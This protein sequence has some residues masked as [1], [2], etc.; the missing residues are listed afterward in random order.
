MSRNA[1]TGI[2]IT[3]PKDWVF[4]RAESWAV[5]T[6]APKGAPEKDWANE[7]AAAPRTML[8]S[9]THPY[10]DLLEE[11]AHH[12]SPPHYHTALEVMVVLT[13]RMIINGEWCDAGSVILVPANE[14]Y[15]HAT[16]DQACLIAV[17]RPVDRGLL[18]PGADTRAARG[19]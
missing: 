13:G 4:R 12:Y 10:V 17:I 7:I 5:R 14:E 16:S 15:W 11:P 18:V 19:G 1:L 6:A 3:T 8:L 2:Q 9:G